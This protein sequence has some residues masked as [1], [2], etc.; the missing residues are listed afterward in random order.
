MLVD[1]P[2]AATAVVN[3]DT[4]P[5]GTHIEWT[6]EPDTSVPGEQTASIT[7][8]YPDGTKDVVETTLTVGESLSTTHTPFW[9]QTHA[10]PGARVTLPQVG[11]RSLPAGTT[12]SA[13]G[14]NRGRGIS[15][16]ERFGS[17]CGT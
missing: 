11:D 10:Q 2:S 15:P 1:A 3:A 9:D 14:L 16:K 12:S 4:F 5:P 7:V 8:T 13:A 17:M 6:T